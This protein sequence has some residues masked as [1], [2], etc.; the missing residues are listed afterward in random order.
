MQNNTRNLTLVKTGVTGIVASLGASLNGN[1]LHEG[2]ETLNT[3]AAMTMEWLG[4]PSY[5][6]SLMCHSEEMNEVITLCTALDLDALD[7]GTV[8]ELIV[9]GF[10]ATRL[11]QI[12]LRNRVVQS[13]NSV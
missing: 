9:S 5:G 8:V 2:M 7:E 6:R 10:Q 3:T 13:M 11:G 1:T 12:E 4:V